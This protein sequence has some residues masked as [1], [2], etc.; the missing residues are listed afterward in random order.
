MIKPALRRVVLATVFATAVVSA[1]LV[2]SEETPAPAP[3][4]RA[5]KSP[6]PGS[7]PAAQRSRT[8]ES[9][10]PAVLNYQRSMEAGVEVVD[11]FESRPVPGAS[12]AQVK[13]EPPKLPFAYVGLIEESG[14][15]KVVLAQGE[16]MHI[17]AQ[18]EQFGSSYRLE[19]VGAEE[20]VLTYLPLGARQTLPTGGPK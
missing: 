17:V 7:V 15:R 11:L 9:E 6:P 2:P 16:Q 14:R 13:P 10:V 12:P 19:E 1:A 18:G 8:R 4:R 5:A 3:A 20:L